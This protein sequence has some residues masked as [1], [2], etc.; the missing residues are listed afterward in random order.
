MEE[1]DRGEDCVSRDDGHDG[2]FCVQGLEVVRTR[3]RVNE[4]RSMWLSYV[5]RERVTGHGIEMIDMSALLSFVVRL[6]LLETQK[7]PVQCLSQIRLRF[8]LRDRGSFNSG[9]SYHQP[10]LSLSLANNSR[11]PSHHG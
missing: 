8:R 9:S 3:Q 10:A 6:I 2:C 5:V 1:G 4:L 7:P 11:E